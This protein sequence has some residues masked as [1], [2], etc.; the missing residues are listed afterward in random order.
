MLIERMLLRQRRDVLKHLRKIVFDRQEQ[1]MDALAQ[2]MNKPPL[3]SFA[4][5]IIPTL[6]EIDF[7]LKNLSKWMRP[8]RVATPRAFFPAKSYIMSRPKGRVL[9]IAAWNYPFQ[10]SLIPAIGAIAAGNRVVIKPSEMAPQT[11]SLIKDIFEDDFFNN[12]F[13]VVEGG[14]SETTELL[15]EKFDHIFFTGG[16]QVGKVVMAAASNTLTP[17]TLELGGKSPAIVLSN[18]DESA[19][20]IVWGKFFNSGQTCVAPDYVL[21]DRKLSSQF[22]ERVNFYIQEFYGKIPLGSVDLA[23]IVNERHFN[24]LKALI[25]KSE[26]LLGGE[27]DRTGLRMSPTV[28]RSNPS[29]MEEEIFGPI[30]P[31]VEIDDEDEA[32]EFITSREKPLALYI[33]S[34]DRKIQKKVLTQTDAGGVCI[35]D[36]L[37]HLSN[38]H[39][40]FGGIGNSGMGNYHGKY[41]FDT[42][43]HQKSVMKRS[44]LFD[45]P[46]RYPPYSGRLK[47]MRLLQKLRLF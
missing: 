10:L 45:I 20:R 22:I 4:S 7:A 40:P 37:I 44:F 33:F 8:K 1:I 42:F 21:I 14:V 39:L 6:S 3:E 5:E 15:L 23:S 24:R 43:S 28:V 16:S 36:T 38:P 31:I 47:I 9:I 46:M 19:K 26:V 11:S 30:L 35:N 34:G 13:E 41:S 25:D 2:D 29:N 32:I 18:V 12:Y 27:Y 17:V